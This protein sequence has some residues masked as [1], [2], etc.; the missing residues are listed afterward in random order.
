MLESNVNSK[1]ICKAIEATINPYEEKEVEKVDENVTIKLG[2]NQKEIVNLAK[3]LGLPSDGFIQ[4]RIVRAQDLVKSNK[5]SQIDDDIFRVRSQYEPQKSYIVNLNHGHPSCDCPDGEHTC[6]CKH[7]IASMLYLRDKQAEQMTIIRIIK[8]TESDGWRWCWLIKQGNKRIMIYDEHDRRLFCNCGAHYGDCE[9]KRLVIETTKKKLEQK[10]VV[11]ECGSNEAKALQDKLNSQSDSQNDSG[12]G[13]HKAP[14]QDDIDPLSRPFVESDKLDEQQILTGEGGNAHYLESVAELKANIQKYIRKQRKQIEK[15]QEYVISYQGVMR[16][17]EKHQITFE[18]S[19]HSDTHTVIAKGR[20]G[21][22]ERASG[23]PINGNEVIAMELAKRNAARQLLPLEEIKAMEKKAQLKAEFDWCIAYEKCTKLAG[24]KPQVDIVINDLVQAGKLRQDNPS[25]YNRIEWRMIYDTIEKENDDSND[26]GDNPPSDNSSDNWEA[27]LQK[28]IDAASYIQRVDWLKVDLQKENIISKEY[29]SQWSDDDF[30]LL[31]Q[32][33]ELD[34]SLFE[35]EIGDGFMIIKED[36]F[37]DYDFPRRYR[38]LIVDA[39]TKELRQRC[40]VC[41]KNKTEV[42]KLSDDLIFWERYQIKCAVCSICQKRTSKA[43]MTAY[44]DRLYHQSPNSAETAG[45]PKTAE[46]FIEKCKEALKRVRL[47][48]V[49]ETNPELSNNDNGN[50]DKRKI[51]MDRKLHTWLIKAD[52][53]K[54][55]ISCA[56]ICQQFESKQNPKII[57]R[58]RQGIDSGADISTI[59]LN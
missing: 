4:R 1:N 20:C 57:S 46:E 47:E 51:Q 5:V 21:R 44:F 52:G 32:A 45:L 6:H 55:K 15:L 34:S 26:G 54:K 2:F 43:D 25:G 53:T 29:P 7:R 8:G 12:N 42:S 13:A 16:L 39:K 24:G 30:R 19:I 38:F 59:E 41:G 11:N 28:C 18:T 58:L 9:H 56:E 33:C 49:S 36:N 22:N 31:H 35:F 10:P 17:A 50:G 3:D 40:F 37:N 23:K 14:S 48:Q 27:K